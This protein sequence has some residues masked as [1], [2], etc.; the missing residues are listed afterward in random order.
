MDNQSKCDNQKILNIDNGIIPASSQQIKDNFKIDNSQFGLLGTSM[1]FGVIFGG[2]FAGKLYLK[3]NSKTILLIAILFQTCTLYLFTFFTQ[4]Y[5]LFATR[6]L[7]G[8]CQ[9][10]LLVFF[11]VW[12]DLKGSQKKTL[13]LTCLHL[14][15]PLG[16]FT[17]YTLTSLISQTLNYKWSFYIQSILII[18]SF[19]LILIHKTEKLSLIKNQQKKPKASPNNSPEAQKNQSMIYQMDPPYSPYEIIDENYQQLILEK[20]Q[21]IQ[22]KSY[23]QNLKE[24]LKTPI[25]LLSI[26]TISLLYF[27]VTGIQYWMSDYFQRVLNVDKYNTMVSYSLVSLTAPTSGV[28]FGGILSHKLGGYEHFNTKKICLILSILSSS[29]ACPVPFVDNYIYVSILIWF[30]LFFGAGMVPGLTGM[31]TSSIQKYL[32]PFGNSFFQIFAGLLGFLPAP[33]LY[34]VFCDKIGQRAGM[35]MLMYVSFFGVL[36]SFLVF[37]VGFFEKKKQEITNQVIKEE[38]TEDDKSVGVQIKIDSTM[39][40]EYKTRCCSQKQSEKFNESSDINIF[41][42]K[43]INHQNDNNE[44]QEAFLQ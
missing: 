24:I 2:F 43:K 5:F 10:F 6:F 21:N 20:E 26:S 9:V 13:W 36:L 40:E 12:I 28:V 3:N 33:A 44:I 14:G 41:V 27:I 25:Y 42:V 31:M 16:I 38:V 11:P 18:I 1:Y 22:S 17:G 32:R 29:V 37:I 30:L 8:I 34:G 39:N 4:V 7:T 23:F 15:V 19:L 35:F